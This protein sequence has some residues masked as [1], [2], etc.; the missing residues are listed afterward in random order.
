MIIWITVAKCSCRAQAPLPDL[1]IQ[2]QLSII[3]EEGLATG[4][5]V[6]PPVL[7]RSSYSSRV[8]FN[9]DTCGCLL[10]KNK[11]QLAH[12]TNETQLQKCNDIYSASCQQTHM[13]YESFQMWIKTK[14][15][16]ESKFPDPKETWFGRGAARWLQ[17][18]SEE[19]TGSS[20]KGEGERK[21]HYLFLKR[22]E[23]GNKKIY[24][25][26]RHTYFKEKD[27]LEDFG[28]AALLLQCSCHCDPQM[29]QR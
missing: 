8:S 24:Y 10:D 3:P 12:I 5:S 22:K 20:A 4:V 16:C 9:E 29:E 13:H 23:L 28:A 15:V 18:C 19:Q 2:G 1:S 26:A 14:S 21:S 27:A 7:Q 17:L 25:T 6:Q 11:S